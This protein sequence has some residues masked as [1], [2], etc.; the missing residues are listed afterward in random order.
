MY[1]Y[2]YTCRYRY[3]YRYRYIYRCRY[4]YRYRYRYMYIY[5]YIYMKICIYAETVS[6]S[7]MVKIQ[8][9]IAAIDTVLAATWLVVVCFKKYDTC[10]CFKKYKYVSR[11]I[12][13]RIQI[14]IERERDIILASA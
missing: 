10:V 13:A 11:S 4:I 3:R 5:K 1:I 9:N 14:Y 6:R 12:M 8:M 7:R 2:I